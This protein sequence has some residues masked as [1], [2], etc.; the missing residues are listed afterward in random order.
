M[1]NTPDL[2]AP[3]AVERFIAQFESGAQGCSMDC[4]DAQAFAEDLRALSA[5]RDALKAALAEAVGAREDAIDTLNAW[6]DRRKLA[7]E[8]IDESVLNAARGYLRTSRSGGMDKETSDMIEGVIED[9]ARLSVFADLFARADL[10]DPMQ[11]ERV[12]ALVKAVKEMPQD[13]YDDNCDCKPCDALHAAL[14]DMGV[15]R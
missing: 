1:T 4:D 11:D 9:M 13:W 8:A 6:F 3:E 14:R 7:H 12:K 10:C 5:E 15:E 2:T